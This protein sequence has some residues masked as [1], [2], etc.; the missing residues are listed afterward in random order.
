MGNYQKTATP[1]IYVNIAEYLQSVGHAVPEY[2]TTL[3]YHQS[4]SS[5]YDPPGVAEPDPYAEFGVQTPYAQFPEG[6]LDENS[7]LFLLG[8]QWRSGVPTLFFYDSGTPL[9][10]HTILDRTNIGAWRFDGGGETQVKIGRLDWMYSAI[11]G[12]FYD[13]PLS[14]DLNISLSIDFSGSDVTKTKFGSELSNTMGNKNPLLYYHSATLG[15]LWDYTVWG[16]WSGGSRVGRRVWNVSFSFYE[17]SLLFP[18]NASIRTSSADEDDPVNHLFED[19]TF[20]KVLQFTQG[21]NL[22][23]LFCSD[24]DN[25]SLDNHAIAKIDSKSIRFKQISNSMKSV[26]LKIREVW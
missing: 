22:P 3:P 11:L 15:K 23:F 17:P 9:T 8:A 6:V 26:S 24:K 19:S 25:P 13:F 16:P 12:F 1:R 4:K 21:G 10:L 18:K 20:Q 14:A 7:F 2:F 5:D